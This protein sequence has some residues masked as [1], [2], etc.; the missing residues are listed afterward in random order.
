MPFT[1]QRMP[2][3][4]LVCGLLAG[5]LLSALV[6][7]TTLA[8]GSFRISRLEQGE[9][10]LTNEQQQLAAQVAT[11]RSATVIERTAYQLGMRRVGVIQFVNLKDGQVESDAGSGADSQIN[12]PGYTP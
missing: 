12:V 6:I 2:F 8:S 5:A 1:A 11:E 9:S 7:S 10:Q 4:V 3:L